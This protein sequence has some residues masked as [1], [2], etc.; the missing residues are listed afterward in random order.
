MHALKQSFPS[1]SLECIDA[2]SRFFAA[3]KG[4]TDPEKKRKIIGGLF[5]DVFEEAIQKKNIPVEGTLLLQ[6][7]VNPNRKP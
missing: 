1:I 4:V 6:V 7:I 3:L 5:I 2:S